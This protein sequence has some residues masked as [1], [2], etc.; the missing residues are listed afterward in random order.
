MKKCSSCGETKEITDF[1][2]NRSRKDGLQNQCKDCSKKTNKKWMDKNRERIRDYQRDYH[3]KTKPCVYRIK[4]KQDGRYYLG[5][6]TLPLWE[7]TSH[8]FSQRSDESSPFTK[9]NKDDWIIE[10]LCYGTKKQVKDLEKDLLI[11]RV[12]IDPNCLNK[13]K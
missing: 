7:R 13:L 6:T 8:H 2:K 11:T 10:A 9:E 4:H 5:Q 3:A 1:Y 12:G